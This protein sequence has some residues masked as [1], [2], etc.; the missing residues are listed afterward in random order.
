MANIHDSRTDE[1]ETPGTRFSRGRRHGY[2]GASEAHVAL[3]R[4]GRR[5]SPAL[6]SGGF[7]K[8]LSYDARR[9][10]RG[11]NLLEQ[12]LPK[13]APRPSV[14]AIVDRGRRTVFGRHVTPTVF[15]L[16]NVQ[17]AADDTAI[18]DARLTGLA[19]RQM[20]IQTKQQIVWVPYLVFLVLDWAQLAKC[21]SR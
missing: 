7:R 10:S 1:A 11:R 20:R 3:G 6:V 12:A 15:R 5:C 9:D 17:D 14:V 19:A 2:G 16:E 4:G 21:S 13:P 18:I 8:R